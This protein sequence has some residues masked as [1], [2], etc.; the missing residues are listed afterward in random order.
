MSVLIDIGNGHQ[1]KW[2]AF[3]GDEHSMLEIHHRRTNG[4]PCRSHIPIVGGAWAR[5]FTPGS[6]FGWDMVSIE[7]LTLA[8]SILC[9]CGDHGFI[10]GGRW[11]PA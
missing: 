6:V 5:E 10:R 2:R 3:E 4:A 9:G 8:P 1:I 7:P 11:V